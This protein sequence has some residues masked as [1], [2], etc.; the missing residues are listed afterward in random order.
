MRS[1]SLAVQPHLRQ[2]LSLDAVGT[3]CVGQEQLPL[4]QGGVLPQM[5]ALAHRGRLANVV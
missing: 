2:R 5:A 4:R 1:G 3:V